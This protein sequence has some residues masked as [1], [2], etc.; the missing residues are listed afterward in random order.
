MKRRRLLASVSA[1]AVGFGAGC[2]AEGDGP[3]GTD[4]PP[5]EPTDTE[6]PSSTPTSTPS[7]T[8]SPSGPDRDGQPSVRGHSIETVKTACMS[9]DEG[10]AEVSFSGT[11]VDIEGT[12]ETPTPCYEAVVES[13]VVTAGELRVQVAFVRDGSDACVQ[14]IGAVEYAATVDLDTTD[15]IETV[16]VTH[17]E[18]GDGFTETRSDDEPHASP[19]DDPER[20]SMDDPGSDPDP[21]LAVSLDNEHDE[22]HTIRVEIRREG[23]ETVYA[24]THE[25]AAGSERE[26]YNLREA[27]PDGVETFEITAT[28]DGETESMRVETSTCYGEAIVSVTDD[29]MLY[30]YYAIC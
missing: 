7:P 20:T 21:D 1:L 6:P 18:N 17:G 27:S 24:E 4:P 30:P 19:T 29:G 22:D 3:A 12:G 10:E 14:C 5:D 9:G 28:M 11:A 25:I 8:P 23:G 13:A 2:V 16:T 15:A 26:V